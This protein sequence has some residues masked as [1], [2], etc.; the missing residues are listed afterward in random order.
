MRATVE[1]SEPAG[2]DLVTGARS[3]IG[4]ARLILPRCVPR[5]FLV[6]AVA[7]LLGSGCSTLIKPTRPS[8]SL[9]ADGARLP[10]VVFDGEQITIREPGV[11]LSPSRSWQRE[12]ANYTAT[13]LN[14]LLA[15]DDDAP[16][17]RTIV[18]FDLAGPSAIQLGIWKEMTI[19]LT[20]T[21][22]D[23][24]VVKSEPV[25]GHI[26]DAFEYAAVTGLGVGGTVL[27]V[28]AVVS[29]V[30]FMFNPPTLLT[31]GIFF[32]ALIGGI[33]VN[34]GQS[35]SQHLVAGSEET[36]WSNLYAAALR[37]HARDI[38]HDIGRGP[39][40]GARPAV[41][42]PGLPAPSE[43]PP[44][45][46]DPADDGPPTPQPTPLPVGTSIGS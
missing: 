3:T 17:A 21:L 44:A 5:F 40:A 39:P 37:K 23:G 22:P 6:A 26:D 38:R 1:R 18:S 4:S 34:I 11:P 2:L 43:Q 46:L 10:G 36:R 32:G 7:V 28:A 27:D 24:T 19:T 35:V 20:S 45:L 25:V 13:S 29:F 15:T 8:S 16:V 41:P 31:G 12:V 14:T 30:F 33:V 42:P 9:A